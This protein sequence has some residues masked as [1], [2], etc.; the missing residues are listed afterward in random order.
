MRKIFVFVLAILPFLNGFSQSSEYSIWS[1]SIETGFCIFDGDVSQSR[2]QLLPQSINEVSYGGTVEY[3]ISPI[4]GLALDFYHFPLSG[5]NNDISFYTPLN[6]SDINAT[7][8]FTKLILPRSRSKVSILGAIGIGYAAYESN[9]RSPDPDNSPVISLP[10]QALSIPVTFSLEYNISK[11]YA[12]GGKIHYR[13]YNKD[14]MEGD[15]RYN[16]KG[17]TNDYIGSGMVYLRYK[18]NSLKKRDHRRNIDMNQFDPPCC[19]EIDNDKEKTNAKLDSII[20]IF[21]TQM[22]EQNTK[23]DSLTNLLSEN[24]PDDDKDGVPNV[25]DKEPHTPLNTP[26]D[27]WGRTIVMPEVIT[28]VTVKQDALPKVDD[29]MPAVF[30]DFDKTGLDDTALEAIRKVSAKMKADP[31]LIVEVRGY[32][33]AMGNISYNEKLSQR[34]SNKV[35]A[36]MMRVWGIPGNR[37]IANGKGKVIEPVTKYRPNRRCDFFFSK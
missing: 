5:R 18:F 2:M 8:N 30:F 12:I 4:W 7:I 34:R 1:A 33:D 3:A 26:V 20:R 31:S 9:Y 28:K 24:G 13:A 27:F 29:N 14:N 25:R 10:G 35:K 15:P 21:K 19:A 32:C 16:Y 36:E 17:V 6:T 37:I 11:L 22:A 23:I